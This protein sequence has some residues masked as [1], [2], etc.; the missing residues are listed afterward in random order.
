MT[1]GAAAT[2][3]ALVGE[4]AGER[5]PRYALVYSARG[6]A[7]PATDPAPDA[8]GALLGPGRARVVREL[9]RPATSTQLAQAKSSEPGSE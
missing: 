3:A 1:N 5:P 4:L 8:L 2:L 6:T 7:A 9:T